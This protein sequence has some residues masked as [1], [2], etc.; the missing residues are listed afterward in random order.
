M[1]IEVREMV[2]KATVVPDAAS[3]GAASS[4]EGGSANSVEIVQLC[5]EKVLEI[6]K[7]KDER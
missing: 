7:D 3:S 5:V 2:I 4:G 6:L 1:P